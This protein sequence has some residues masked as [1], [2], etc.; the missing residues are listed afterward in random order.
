MSC[1]WIPMVALQAAIEVSLGW[2]LLWMRMFMSE[3]LPPIPFQ[4]TSAGMLAGIGH[5]LKSRTCFQIDT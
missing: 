4:S 1:T 5:F 3:L 2:L